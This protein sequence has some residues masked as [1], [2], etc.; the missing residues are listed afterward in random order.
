M[1]ID[2]EIKHLGPLE[3]VGAAIVEYVRAG[4]E[5]G[6]ITSEFR[7]Y[8]R[9]WTL[10]PDNWINLCFVHTRKYR[11]HVTLGVWPEVLE[12]MKQRLRVKKT[13][14]PT[15]SRITIDDVMQLPAALIYIE[16]AYYAS[17]NGY[18]TS[19]GKKP[20]R[21]T[22]HPKSKAEWLTAHVEF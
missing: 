18:R 19:V 15:W 7:H 5:W 14:P 4:A 6:K 21:P 8:S 16:G 22:C 9:G 3:C 11:I 20:D 2:E 10:E 12:D 17:D 1:S 13:K